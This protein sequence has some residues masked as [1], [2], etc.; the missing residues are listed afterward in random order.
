MARIPIL[1][2]LAIS[3]VVFEMLEAFVPSLELAHGDGLVLAAETAP[4]E[5]LPIASYLTRLELHPHF[6]IAK[7]MPL[8]VPRKGSLG[9]EEPRADAYPT[10][11]VGDVAAPFRWLAVA[12][13]MV[14]PVLFVIEFLIALIVGAAVRARRRHLGVLRRFW[15]GGSLRSHFLGHASRRSIHGYEPDSVLGGR[16]ED[17]R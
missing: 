15:V 2:P 6:A 11:R 7:A 8:E 4:P 17:S 10:V 13:F 5:S 1:D 9:E 3:E 12:N 14:N 16:L